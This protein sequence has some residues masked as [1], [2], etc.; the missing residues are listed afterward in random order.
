[1]N[2]GA[3][4]Y[5]MEHSARF[6]CGAG[7]VSSPRVF[8]AIELTGSRFFHRW[9]RTRSFF[10]KQFENRQRN[11]NSLCTCAFTSINQIK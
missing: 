4:W 11:L 2:Y 5:I 10:H 1:M 8:E 7:V 3:A 6:R 9:G